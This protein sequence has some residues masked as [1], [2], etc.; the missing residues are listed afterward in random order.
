M[1]VQRPFAASVLA[2]Q[3]KRTIVKG[4]RAVGKTSLA[5][6]ELESRG[7]AYYSLAE[8][9]TYD[10]ASRNLS[11]WVNGLKLPA[12]IG[13]AQ[14]IPELPL[15]IKER[16]DRLP[17]TVFQIVLTGSASINRK[18]LEGQDPLARRSRR[19]T[20]HPLT[21]REIVQN[22]SSIADDL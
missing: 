14:R 17:N 19:L 18:R 3:S 1:Y 15:A 21:R 20:L 6:N 8:Q 10:S 2:C 22:P 4:T 13:E 9:K 12:I 11:E 5:R 16:V 7:F